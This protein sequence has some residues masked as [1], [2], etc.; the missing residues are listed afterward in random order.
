[1]EAYFS[2]DI[3]AEMSA[4]QRVRDTR[5]SRLR[6]HAGEETFTV[7]KLW[8]GGFAVDAETTPHLRG[9]VD[10]YDSATH[11][12]QCLIM[13]SDRNGRFMR[14]EFK[15][16]TDILDEVPVDYEKDETGPIALLR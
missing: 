5:K 15:R 13:R 2:K 3:M 10:I 1:M 16:K 12:A 7:V 4:A 14:Y 11:L 6:V 8:D 9:L